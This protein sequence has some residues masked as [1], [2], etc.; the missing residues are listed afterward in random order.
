MSVSGQ[1]GSK[2]GA[3]LAPQFDEMFA[4]LWNVFNVRQAIRERA[5]TWDPEIRFSLK[6]ATETRIRAWIRDF[7][8]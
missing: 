8:D 4:A 7:V 2:A 5:L 3:K 6:L 1:G